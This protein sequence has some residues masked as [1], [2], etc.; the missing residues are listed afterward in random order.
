MRRSRV[1]LLWFF[2]SFATLMSAVGFADGGHQHPCKPADMYRLDLDNAADA[3]SFNYDDRRRTTP[4]AEVA[5]VETSLA[6]ATASLAELPGSDGWIVWPLSGSPLAVI[7]YVDDETACQLSCWNGQD[8]SN[9]TEPADVLEL[10]AALSGCI[11]GPWI[12]QQEIVAS[13]DVW[14]GDCDDYRCG[15][16]GEFRCCEE[17]DYRCGLA[18]TPI[19]VDNVP[20]DDLCADD[21]VLFQAAAACA[22][23]PSQLLWQQAIERSARCEFAW[24][25][26]NDFVDG[27][28]AGWLDQRALLKSAEAWR[29][30]G[31]AAW[32]VVDEMIQQR[33]EV[34]SATSR[35]LVGWLQ[36]TLENAQRPARALSSEPSETWPNLGRAHGSLLSL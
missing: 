27:S 17:D 33:D 1:G 20:A 9:R 16:R 35:G 32:N 25:G 26:C 6:P 19:G 31:R 5:A 11:V 36:S 34:L 23:V 3:C 12:D 13:Q 8:E 15:D 29:A 30:I 10:A 21:E 7:L 2:G 18:P 14:A 22:G 24:S 28:V 4:A